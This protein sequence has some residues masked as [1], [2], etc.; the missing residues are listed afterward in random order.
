MERTGMSDA[1]G[2]ITAFYTV[3]V[4]GDDMA[5]PVADETRSAFHQH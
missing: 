2:S 4:E 3:L 5:E 1:G